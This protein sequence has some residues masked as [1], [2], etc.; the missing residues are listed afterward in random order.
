MIHGV[1]AGGR[2][3]A[4]ALGRRMRVLQIGVRGLE[5]KELAHERVKL[6]VGNLGAVLLVIQDFVMA[7]QITKLGDAA[8]GVS[9]DESSI[10]YLSRL[11]T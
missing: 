8:G 7:D 6:G 11:S 4:H 3:T 9:D 5:R 2:L 1:E 10:A